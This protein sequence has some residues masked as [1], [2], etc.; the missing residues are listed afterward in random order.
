MELPT[1]E[2]IRERLLDTDQF[3]YLRQNKFPGLTKPEWI[4]EDRLKALEDAEKTE[5]EEDEEVEDDPDREPHV[6]DI[7]GRWAEHVVKVDRVQRVVKGGSVMK[8]RALVVCGNL[9][10]AGGFAYGKGA[11]P[12][13]A[14]ARASRKSKKRLFFID[15]FKGVALAHDVQG[16]H[17]NCLVPIHLR[18]IEDKIRHPLS[19]DG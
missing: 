13:E 7:I 17:N 8:Y 4:E 5:A 9:M 19:P 6:S 2:Q 10:G 14:I 3:G 16:K 18:P 1:L 11:T 12:Q 15:R